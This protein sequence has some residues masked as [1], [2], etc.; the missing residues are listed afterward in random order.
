MMHRELYFQLRLWLYVYI[1]HIMC[2]KTKELKKAPDVY[3]NP[4]NQ[5]HRQLRV[6]SWWCISETAH[7]TVSLLLQT[8]TS[9]VIGS[10]KRLIE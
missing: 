4:S 3:L 8:T 7:E 5:G 10:N 9:Y 1:V 6:V 2:I